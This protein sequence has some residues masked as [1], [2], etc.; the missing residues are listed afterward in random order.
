MFEQFAKE[1]GRKSELVEL[2]VF[3]G[4]DFQNPLPIGEQSRNRFGALQTSCTYCGECD[5]GCNTQSKNTLDLNYLYVAEHRYQAQILTEHLAQR[6]VPL[7]TIRPNG[8]QQDDPQADG[9][10]GFA[11]Y[12][13]NLADKSVVRVL[14]SRV[15]VSAGTLNTT[16]L[17]L[18]CRDV[19]HTLPRISAKLG[20]SYSGNGDFL[21]FVVGTD[22][23]A[24]P[25]YGPVITQRVD[26]N[27]FEDFDPRR[28]FIVEDASYPNFASWFVEGAKPLSFRIPSLI[29][30]MKH[31]FRRFAKGQSMGS[32]GW[33]LGDL[34]SNDLSMNTAV[35]L[36]MGIDSSNGV[37]TLDKANTIHVD[38]PSHQSQ[39]LYQAI[40]GAGQKFREV[41]C[42]KTF[43]PLPT[44]GL[45]PWTFKSWPWS[46]TRKNVSVHSLGGCIL[47]DSPE[48]GVTS[49]DRTDFG[50]VFGYRN[51]FVADGALL[52]TAVG[53]NPTA[54]I[55][56]ICEM[57]SEGI[58]NQKPDAKL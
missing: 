47:G 51:L 21:S 2:N 39:D 22:R 50:Q 37:M 45:W 15:I 42:G 34:L 29:R 14:T 16:E 43:F 52:P 6:I 25:N 7:G 48:K 10:N 54:T 41:F 31:W 40:L 36:C 24:N 56:A 9:S 44:W 49:S 28:A 13:M 46:A 32:A 12:Y 33:A 27:L 38:W 58:T 18:R 3:F 57:V 4:N 5:V 35:L 1:V 55:S 26:Y 53:A 17:L 20:H 8:E 23:D 30:L 11:V 19:F